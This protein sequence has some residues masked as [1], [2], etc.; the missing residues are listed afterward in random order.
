MI[1]S[2]ATIDSTTSSLSQKA[3][4]NK[5]EAVH[6]LAET[7]DK[8]RRLDK[9]LR[10]AFTCIEH[11]KEELDKVKRKKVEVTITSRVVDGAST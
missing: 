8:I 10:F 9:D 5:R 7:K 3:S 1:V 4:S 6:E 2:D 11:L